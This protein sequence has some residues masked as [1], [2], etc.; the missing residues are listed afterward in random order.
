MMMSVG[1]AWWSKTN[2]YYFWGDTPEDRESMCSFLDGKTCVTFN[3][4]SYDSKVLL[5]NDCK[6]GSDNSTSNSKHGWYNKDIYL[7]MWRKVLAHPGSAQQILDDLAK[8]KNIPYGVFNLDAILQAT[9]KTKKNSNGEEAV[10]YYQTGQ[11]SK[12]YEYVLQ[13][14]ICERDLYQFI[15]RFG[16]LINGNYDIVSFIK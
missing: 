1:C 11:I 7:S 6:I 2:K 8:A 15:K 4:I 14:V 13:D 10:N 12:L 16:Y 9:L 5:G 3:G